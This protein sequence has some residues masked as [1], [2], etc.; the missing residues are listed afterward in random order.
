VEANFPGLDVARPD[1][2]PDRRTLFHPIPLFLS[3]LD[4][5][6][7][8][9]GADRIAVETPRGSQGF[10]KRVA[11][12]QNRILAV[13]LWRDR[14]DDNLLGSDAG[15][16][17]QAVVVRMRHDQGADEACGNTPRG[18]VRELLCALAGGEADLLRL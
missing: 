16:K 2:D 15:R 14:D 3:P 10:R 17:H 4:V 13:L 1:L 5:A 8:D 11:C 6:H 12:V 9:E 18:G 7:I